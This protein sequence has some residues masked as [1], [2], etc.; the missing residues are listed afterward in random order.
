[1]QILNRKQQNK[2][3]I[4]VWSAKQLGSADFNTLFWQVFQLSKDI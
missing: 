3:I 2:K 1:M 4:N